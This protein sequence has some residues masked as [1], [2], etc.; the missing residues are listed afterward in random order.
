MDYLIPVSQEEV[1][2][3]DD[4]LVGE[5]VQDNMLGA[6]PKGGRK[7]RPRFEKKLNRVK[8]GSFLKGAK[9]IILS[10]IRGGALLVSGATGTVNLFG[11]NQSTL[12]AY[13][14]SQVG[15]NGVLPAPERFLITGI[16]FLFLN[17]NGTV[18]TLSQYKEL[19]QKTTYTF[20]ISNKPMLEGC[21]LDH[22]PP[23]IVAAPDAAGT[24]T[25]PATVAAFNLCAEIDLSLIPIG[26][27]TNAQF[28]L[29]V[30]YTA[31]ALNGKGN[32]YLVG[33]LSGLRSRAVQ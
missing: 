5:I 24:A 20:T 19:V 17:D 9:D 16:R 2:G 28:S 1:Y 8:A 32:V 10:Q 3:E 29:S 12:P 30:N 11:A 7:R 26:I 18:L 4:E 15:Q 25:D 13:V 31:P 23:Q 21:L 6:Y 22:I 14:T 27:P 33:I